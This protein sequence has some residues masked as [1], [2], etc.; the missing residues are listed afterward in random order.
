MWPVINLSAV[1]GLNILSSLKSTMIIIIFDLLQIMIQKV[2][3]K[4]FNF[5]YNLSP[6]GLEYFIA[7]IRT[8]S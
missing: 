2:V 5:S 7:I 1:I 4:Q 6:E 8:K 3:K